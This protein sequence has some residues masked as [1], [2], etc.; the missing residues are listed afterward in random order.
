MESS[1]VLKS[2]TANDIISASLEILFPILTYYGLLEFLK[3]RLL[4]DCG[5]GNGMAVISCMN[6]RIE[7]LLTQYLILSWV[8]ACW[9]FF[10]MHC[11]RRYSRLR[12]VVPFVYLLVVAVSSFMQYS[13]LVSHFLGR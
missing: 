5:V 12:I 1:N 8:A 6:D 13:A 9:M 7:T 3:D 4:F 11:F 2:G 10:L